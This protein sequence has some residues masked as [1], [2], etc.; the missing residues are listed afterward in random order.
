[1]LSIA[2]KNTR[3]AG[4]T[5]IGRVGRSLDSFAYRPELAPEEREQIV[6][7]HDPYNFAGC[8]YDRQASNPV[9]THSL[10]R[11]LE[12]VRNRHGD[13][14]VS[15]KVTDARHARVLAFR[16]GTQDQRRLE[17]PVGLAIGTAFG[18][19]AR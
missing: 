16:N 8:V 11:R 15:R 2:R 1:V 12:A 14:I 5:A 9:Q 7:G 10:R 17:S 4:S 3:G 18:A 13:G 19:M 6:R